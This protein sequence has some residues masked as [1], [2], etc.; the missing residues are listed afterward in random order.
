[1]KICLFG[2]TFNPIHN[3]HLGMCLEAIKNFNFD[4]FFVIPA[5][6]SYF[7]TDVVSK[8]HRAKMVEIALVDLIEKC[9]SNDY[10]CFPEYS[11]IEI[12]REGPSYSIDTIN[13]YKQEYPN[14]EIYFVIGADTVF[15]ILKWYKALDIL[16][17]VNLL[18]LKRSG[19]NEELEHEIDRFKREY[20]A[21]ISV[22]DYSYDISSTE[23]RSMLKCHNEDIKRHLQI[24]ELK[25]IY[26]NKLYLE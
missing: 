5:G 18:V 3:G 24:N 20:K 22:L 13:Y 12:K 25:Y 14:A 2:G 7:K 8:E 15:N 23:I 10:S 4:R 11:D 1:M 26:E 17:S 16:A 19:Y 9:D 6:N 21:N